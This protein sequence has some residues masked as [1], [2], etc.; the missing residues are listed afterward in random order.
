MQ[1]KILII[2]LILVSAFIVAT[3][4]NAAEPNV[5]YTVDTKDLLAI[6]VMGHE[7]LDTTVPVALDGSITFPYLGSL[8]VKGLTL[9]EIEKLISDKLAGGYIKYPVVSVMLVEYKYKK[10]YVY[11]EVVKPGEYKLDEIMTV[12]KAISL[13]EG[14]TLGGIYGEVKIKRM[15]ENRQDYQEIPVDLK[16]GKEDSANGEIPLEAEDIVIVGRN[17]HI[18]VSGEVGIPGKYTLEDELTVM[19]AISLAEGITPEGIY[20]DVKVK[21]KRE[22]DQEYKE[23]SIDLKKGKEGTAKGD[24]LLEAGDAVVVERNKNIYVTGEVE[25]PGEFTLKDKLTVMKAISLA[26][27]ITPEGVVG[28]V[29]VKRKQVGRHEYREIPI[30]LKGE[31]IGIASGDMLLEAEDVVVVERNKVFYA[32]GEVER[33]GKFILEHHTTVLNA[34]SLAGGFSKF[35]SLD[36]VKILKK[37]SDNGGYKSIKVDLKGALQ[38][39]PDKEVLIEPDDI[40][41]ALERLF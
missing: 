9:T 12:F 28:D 8:L 25:E 18:Y 15:Q 20:G 32:Y 1:K 34:I 6:N 7:N 29:K 31:K 39:I 19:K 16:G 3:Q 22:G 36:K 30:D 17:R 23:I 35:G 26:G 40:V 4:T 10:F 24:M 13:A 33:P 27:G 21:R 5:Q 2:V 14:I 41:I 11:G 37:D 38:G